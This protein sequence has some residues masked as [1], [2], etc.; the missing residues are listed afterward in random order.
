[1]VDRLAI[2]VTHPIYV[3]RHLAR[4]LRDL[5]LSRT[6]AALAFTTLLAL[7]PLASVGVATV[8]HF[9]VFETWLNSLE[10]FLLRYMLPVSASTLVHTYVLGFAAHAAELRG[11]SLLFIAVTAVLLF[12][13]VEREIN[14]I[15]RVRRGRPLV[16]RVPVYF[17][18]LTL[19]PLLIGAGIW[20]T[21]WIMAQSRAIIPRSTTLGAWIVAPL[22]IVLT[23]AALALMYKFTPAKPVRWVPAVIAG[24]AAAAAFEVMKHGFAFY[25]THVPTYEII[26][27]AL[28]ALPLFLLW[29]YLC[30][31][32]VLGG[33]LLT[34][35]LDGGGSR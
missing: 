5:D 32:I 4:G 25:V 14:L 6:A 29:L 23:A 31:L 34:A 2:R 21:T 15:F 10:A 26:Y 7:V 3:L 30:W 20:L 33:A 24:A 27:G 22:P 8:A 11:L 18:V 12:A 35:A 9:P 19:G 1:V 16:R 13:M 28:A 17:V